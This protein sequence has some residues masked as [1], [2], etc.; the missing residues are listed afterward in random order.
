MGVAYSYFVHSDWDRWR[1]AV[2]R[3]STRARQFLRLPFP[4]EH[5]NDFGEAACAACHSAV[6]F[7]HI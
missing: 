5:C 1:V 2:Q 7:H 6:F 3:D 4:D